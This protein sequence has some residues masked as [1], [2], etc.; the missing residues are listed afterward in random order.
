MIDRFDT[1]AGPV[2]VKIAVGACRFIA[3]VTR[4]DDEEA[5]KAFI[6]KVSQ[7]FHD[8]TH[9]AYAYKIG[10][11]DTAI[12]RQNDAAEP[13]GT[14][15]PPMLQAIENAGLTNV[16]VVGTRYFG[17]VKL[18]IGGLVRA[19]RACAE[20]GLQAA[21]RITEIFHEPFTVLISYEYIGSVLREIAAGNGEVSNVE[22]GEHGVT[23]FGSV[24]KAA[25]EN[26]QK[27][28]SEATR[29]KAKFILGH[30]NNSL[31]KT[32]G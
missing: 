20:A 8:A 6:A 13:A 15:G 5:A 32:E 28:L 7:E 19:Y 14:A 11:G 12:C 10:L 24:T 27:Q 25:R 30:T 3:S 22:Y 17:G 16:T 21:E 9:N 18:G 31:S 26:L 23:V 4:T 2:Q 29:G 1:V